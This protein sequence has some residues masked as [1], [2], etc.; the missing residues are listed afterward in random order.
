M[1][2]QY[3][4]IVGM[5][6][7]NL[8]FVSAVLLKQFCGYNTTKERCTTGKIVQIIGLEDMIE[9]ENAIRDFQ[10]IEKYNIPK[11][12]SDVIC[13]CYEDTRKE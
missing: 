13:P 9:L 5:D 10:P 7:I 6:G 3:T 2:D 12:I 8:D 4:Y 11:E 1:L